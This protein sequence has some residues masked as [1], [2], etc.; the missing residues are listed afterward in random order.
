MNRYFTV[1]YLLIIFNIGCTNQ[2]PNHV[3]E[4]GIKTIKSPINQLLEQAEIAF[5]KNHLTTPSDLSA[6]RFYLDV[7]RINPHNETALS[8]IN[9]IIEQYLSWALKKADSGNYWQA[10]LYVQRAKSIDVSHPN[11]EP[12]IQSIEERERAVVTKFEVD[13]EQLEARRVN[14][15]L[16]R[17]IARKIS[18]NHA[19][20]TIQ[21]PNDASGRWLYKELNNRVNFRIEAAFERGKQSFV[22]LSH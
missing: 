5:E 16:L 13:P 14:K 9:N 7:L 3:V 17:Q 12:V 4:T 15:I 21:A 10:R 1:C 22:Y 18:E 6:Y 8:G 19:F 11:I 20:V 2:E